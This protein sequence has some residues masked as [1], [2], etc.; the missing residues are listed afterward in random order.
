MLDF[1]IVLIFIEI[2]LINNRRKY[3]SKTHTVEIIKIDGDLGFEIPEEICEELGL[4]QGD[5]MEWVSSDDGSFF[6]KK[7]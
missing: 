2:L 4:E 5:K 6:L 3:M 7:V 1:F